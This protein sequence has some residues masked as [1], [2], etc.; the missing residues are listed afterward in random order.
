MGV[1]TRAARYRIDVSTDTTN[2]TDGTWQQLMG[3]TDFNP[4]VNP[5]IKDT[6]TYDNAGWGSS[7]IT[8]NSWKAVVKVARQLNGGGGFDPAQEAVRACVAKFGSAARIYVR[9]YDRNGL[10]EAYWGRA[11]VEWS[12]SKTSADDVDEATISLTGDGELKVLTTNPWWAGG[13]PVPTLASATPSGVAVGGT[14]T[15]TGQYFTAGTGVAVSHGVKFGATDATGW[16]VLSDTLLVAA[17]PAGSAGSAAITVTNSNG[18][19][20]TLAYTRGA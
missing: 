8:L 5:T 17:M 6:T 20:S 11:I 18:A 4:N 15:I 14:V 19:S 9:W 3:I 12:R 1:S 2:G 10:A 16:V 7:E 13:T